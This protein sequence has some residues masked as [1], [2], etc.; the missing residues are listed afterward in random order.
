MTDGARVLVVGGGGREHAI[1]WKVA[2]SPK[3]AEVVLAPG[4]GGTTAWPSL[5]VS[6]LD[7]IVAAAREGAFDLVIVGPEDPLAAGLADRLREAGIDCFGPGA[8]GARIEASKG[9]ARE[10]MDA[11]GV[12]GPR[13]ARFDDYATALAWLHEVDFQVCIKAD[14]LAAGKGVVV[15]DSFEE[16]DTTLYRYLVLDEL[17]AA[18]REVVIEERLVGEE[19]SALAFTDGTTIA[20]MPLA[21]DHKR[22]REG[23]KGPNT[24]GMGAYAP[25]PGMERWEGFV[26]HRVM[27]PVLDELR[28]RGVDYRGVLYAGLMLT[29]EGPKLL[30]FNCRFGDPEAQ[31]LLPLLESD[32]Y[33]VALAT[34]RRR[35]ATQDVMWSDQRSLTVV[36][37]SAGYPGTVRVGLPI[38]GL[39]QAAAYDGVQVFHAGT[40][41]GPEG[42]LSAG[43]RVLA[44]NAVADTFEIAATQAYSA[45]QHVTLEGMQ[46]RRD[47]GW[48]VLNP[49]GES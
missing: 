16:A 39:T 4:N 46:V 3:V 49:G 29:H 6:D 41:A 43:G 17:G 40:R 35:L 8:A 5:P 44:V 48:R 30:E 47:I 33:E 20:L 26:H 34:A 32:L 2:Q 13:W 25:V 21:Q 10:V 9:F 12:P 11:A 7:G 45:L 37:A 19:L 42:P 1:A 31:T 28:E 23:D 22:L 27:R 24:G 18:G 36:A 38:G 15:C 14:G